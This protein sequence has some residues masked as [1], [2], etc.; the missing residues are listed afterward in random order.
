VETTSE[1]RPGKAGTRELA[2]GALATDILPGG[3][4]AHRRRNRLYA[5][6]AMDRLGLLEE[7][8]LVRA[9]DSRPALRWLVDEDGARWGILTELG[10]IRDPES[11]D[12]AVRWV[13]ENRPKTKEA[14]TEI[15]QLRRGT[16]GLRSGETEDRGYSSRTPSTSGLNPP[17]GEV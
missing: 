11:F 15:R 1:N 14:T 6:R 7:G 4:E 2:G 10:R 3:T 12:F 16:R 9:L 8:A 5:L 17:V 13:L